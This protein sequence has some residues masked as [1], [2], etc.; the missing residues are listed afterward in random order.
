ML[1]ARTTEK[2]GSA[3]GISL[4]RGNEAATPYERCVFRS[5][6][7]FRVDRKTQHRAKH[8]SYSI[9]AKRD[10]CLPRYARWLAIP[11]DPKSRIDRNS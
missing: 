9:P 11:V 2:N 3:K 7:F 6:R 5:I 4:G 8:G 1:R 10:D